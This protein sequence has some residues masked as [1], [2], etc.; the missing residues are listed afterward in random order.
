M[1]EFLKLAWKPLLALAVAGAVWLAIHNWGDS[2]YASG[3]IHKN[4]EWLVKQNKAER[5][6]RQA[7]QTQ[8]DTATA[9]DKRNAEIIAGLNHQVDDAVGDL[10]LANRLLTAARARTSTSHPVHEAADQPGTAPASGTQSDRL[11]D[12]VAAAIG[13]CRRNGA[14]LT[15]LIAEVVPQ[16]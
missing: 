9:T 13:E 5:E 16:L 10:S 12:S 3:E 14:R 15:A 6:A 1:I 11:A 4:A 2:R 8:L 7:L